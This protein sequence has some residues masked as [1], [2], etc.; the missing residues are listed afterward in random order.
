MLRLMR[1]YA[2]TSLIHINTRQHHGENHYISLWSI[3]ICFFLSWECYVFQRR[4]LQRRDTC[5]HC[6]DGR[7]NGGPKI[8]PAF[9]WVSRSLFLAKLETFGVENSATVLCFFRKS[10]ETPRSLTCFFCRIGKNP[11]FA[12]LTRTEPCSHSKVA[13]ARRKVQY[14][15]NLG[16]VRTKDSR[17]RGPIDHPLRSKRTL[18]IVKLTFEVN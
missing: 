13:A 3:C 17:T 15:L 10:V 16:R 14:P 11:R 7:A 2:K 12:P 6:I 4:V 8:L 5:E 9:G 18:G 1:F